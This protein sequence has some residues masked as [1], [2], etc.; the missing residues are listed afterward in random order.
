[1]STW[2]S[3]RNRVG[4][5]A[6][7]WSRNMDL[8]GSRRNQHSTSPMPSGAH[9]DPQAFLAELVDSVQRAIPADLAARVLTVERR[10]TLGDRIARRPGQIVSLRLMGA[11]DALILSYEPGI[12]WT[13]E[14]A[15]V[16]G[17]VI[18]S[19][20]TMALGAWLTAFAARI[21]SL[22]AHAARDSAQSAQA[23]QALGILPAGADILVREANI[24]GDLRA[25]AA[26]LGGRLP[27]L[28]VTSVER[29]GELL[30]E[31]LPRVSG[32][33]E[34]EVIVLRTAT[35]YLPDTIRAY[36]SI[37]PDWAAAHVFADGMAPAQVLVAQ[38][39]ELERAARRMRDAAVEQDASALLINGRFLAE[40]FA[41]PR[42]DPS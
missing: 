9:S 7:R 32:T 21:A 35:V 10:R 37:P 19:P 18:V 13:P 17:V 20:R 40:R 14:A 11:S 41:T 42:L 8:N 3:R 24:H 4:I 16:H 22:A 31:T 36:L 26:R 23:L 12:G 6:R 28:A 34:Q 2:S 39:N 27:A 29:I 5:P 25:L 33:G 38:L 1:M 15:L 30:S